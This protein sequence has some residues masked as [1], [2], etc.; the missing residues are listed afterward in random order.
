MT[1]APPLGPMAPDPPAAAMPLPTITHIEIRRV[2]NGFVV[3]GINMDV[4]ENTHFG[5]SPQRATFIAGNVEELSK[6]LE[7]IVTGSQL[8]WLPTV[9]LPVWEMQQRR[10]MAMNNQSNEPEGK[11]DEPV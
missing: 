6:L 1:F 10:Q 2:Q 8:K 11:K 7:W 5:T 4:Y 3:A 9:D